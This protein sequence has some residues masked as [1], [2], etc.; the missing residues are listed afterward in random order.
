MTQR[1]RRQASTD[2][3]DEALRAALTPAQHK[4]LRSLEHMNWTLEFM[5]RPLFQ[6]S[7]AVVRNSEGTR[8][9]VLEPDGMLNETAEIDARA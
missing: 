8:R 6:E 1:E 7:I 5:R 3:D 4:T 2:Q 9:A